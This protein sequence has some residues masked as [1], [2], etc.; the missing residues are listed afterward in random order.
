LPIIAE[1]ADWM[2]REPDL[3]PLGNRPAFK[4]LVPPQSEKKN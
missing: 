3:K 4:K 1:Q 2:D